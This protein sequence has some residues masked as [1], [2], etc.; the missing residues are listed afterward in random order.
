MGRPSTIHIAIEVQNG[1]IVR[2]KVGGESVLIAT[3]TLTI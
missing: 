3:G 2:V 1:E